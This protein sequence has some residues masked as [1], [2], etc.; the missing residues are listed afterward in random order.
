MKGGGELTNHTS[1]ILAA[2]EKFGDDEARSFGR[3]VN[4]Y[5]ALFDSG[6]PSQNYEG[7]MIDLSK[8]KNYQKKLSGVELQDNQGLKYVYKAVVEAQGFPGFVAESKGE[9]KEGHGQPR[10]VRLAEDLVFIPYDLAA[11]FLANLAKRVL[12]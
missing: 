6:V 5:K 2:F 7:N 3:T 12:E 9:A 11:E 1:D 10:H 8:D 4:A